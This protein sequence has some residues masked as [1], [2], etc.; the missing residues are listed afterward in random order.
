M[1]ILVRIRSIFAPSENAA[2]LYKELGGLAKHPYWLL[3]APVHIVLGRD[4]LFLP[5]PAPIAVLKSDAEI[6]ISSLNDHFSEIGNQFYLQNDIWFLGLD[7]DPKITTI[8]V[9][10]VVNQ[11]LA[12]FQ[13]TGEGAL[14][15][16]SF[17]NEIQMLLFNHSVNA[18][19]ES[20]GELP[21]NSI[22]FYGLSVI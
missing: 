19:R 1:S 4:S 15:W 3:A 8:A 5:S 2:K 12:S 17:Q 11:N 6:I 22:W 16:A 10:K 14:V 18:I 9:K 7:S 21:I 13:P 20:R